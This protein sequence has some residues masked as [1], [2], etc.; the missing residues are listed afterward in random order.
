MFSKRNYKKAAVIFLTVILIL[1]S[2]QTVMALSGTW[3]QDGSWWWFE[4]DDGS[5]PANV[6]VTIRGNQ[7]AFD[8]NG[9][10]ISN[11]WVHAPGYGWHYCTGSGKIAENQWVGNYYVGSDG[12]MLTNTWTPDGYWV[13]SEGAWDPSVPRQGSGSGTIAGIPNGY[14]SS[15]GIGSDTESYRV[16]CWVENSGGT[17]VVSFGHYERGGS[18]YNYYDNYNP[19]GD[20]LE[21]YMENG[22][23]Y[24]K[25]TKSGHKTYRVEYDGDTLKIHW[26]NVTWNSSKL[27]RVRFQDYSGNGVG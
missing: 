18:P 5:Y 4:C 22:T 17:K 2:A 1:V 11:Q 13:D 24:G 26:E 6:I 25:S 27:I 20:T 12:V 14:Y 9:Y 3:K 15:A 21:L 23:I 16:D 7:Y 10:M 8:V 19:N